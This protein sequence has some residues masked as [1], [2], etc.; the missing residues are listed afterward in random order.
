MCWITCRS[1]DP[2]P[3]V[4][5]ASRP[6]PIRPLSSQE[7]IAILPHTSHLNQNSPL[8]P[9]SV[10]SQHRPRPATSGRQS[11]V[12]IIEQ[13]TPRSSGALA[14]PHHQHDTSPVVLVRTRSQSRNTQDYRRSGGSLNVTE[15]TMVVQKTRRSGSSVVDPRASNASWRSTREKVVIVDARGTR[16]EYYR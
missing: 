5:I 16:R 1:S 15:P 7:P 13:R 8:R 12:V 2:E 9:L 11:Q 3:E 4:V 14:V 10:H 6:I